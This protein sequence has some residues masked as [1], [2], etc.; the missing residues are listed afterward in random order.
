MRHLLDAEPFLLDDVAALRAEILALGPADGRRFE[1]WNLLRDSARRAPGEFGWFVPFVAV[2]TRD[3]DDIA[4][5]RAIIDAYLGKLEAQSFS[6]GLQFHFWCFAFPHAKV[7]LYF[8]WLC[9]VGAYSDEEADAIG[10]QLLEFHFVNFYYGMRDKPEPECVD[11]QALSL[12]LST[13][14]IGHLFSGGAVPSRM[15]EILRRDGLRRLP[16]M[17]SELPESGYTGEGSDYMN[18][19]VAPAIPLAVEVLERVGGERAVLEEP[20]VA[21]GARPV[22]VLRMM[23]RSFMPG[24]LLLPWDN[25]GYQFGSRSALAYGARRTG[26]DLFF[27]VLER[28]VIWTYDIGIGWAYDDLVWTLIWWPSRGPAQRDPDWREWFHPEVGAALARD[29]GDRYVVQMWDESEPVHPTRAHVNPNAVLFSG[30][31]V[32]I[33]ADGS[34]TE[35]AAH[36]FQFDDTWR[37][38]SFLAMDSTSRYNFGD[39]CA[40]AHSVIVLDDREGMRALDPGPQTAAAR[41]DAR[42]VW[43]DVTPI[44]R[45]NLPDVREVSRRTTLHPGGLVT[46]VDRVRAD[47]PHRVTSR[48]VV[49]PEATPIPGGVRVRTPE[50]VTLQIVDA[51]DASEV[52]ISR[53]EH[54]PAKP[55][56]ASVLVDFSREGRDVERVVVALIS[57][58]WETDSPLGPVAVIPD[59]GG[60]LRLADAVAELR[61]TPVRVPGHLPAYLEAELPAATRWWYRLEVEPSRAPRWLRLPVGMHDP[62]LVIDGRDVDLAP[63]RISGALIAPRVPLPVSTRGDDPVEIVLALSVPRGHYDGEGW[64][65]IGMTGGFGLGGEVEE[66]RVQSVER[67]GRRVRVVTTLGVHDLDLGVETEDGR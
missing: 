52:R 7:A 8:Q 31:R 53:A 34:P 37:E 42:G 49:R 16:G 65:T 47:D 6:T 14:L 27:Q 28:E 67:D 43:A 21:G 25:Y 66:E 15:A 63:W 29:D 22:S 24:G 2:M 11:N 23:A 18:C 35:G 45:Q 62:R 30:F 56:D 59:P 20:R 10:A 32:P 61:R 9:S 48:F 36:R 5:A 12:V 26:E 58:E 60:D 40:G 13:T 1:L 51:D 3:P 38:V 64:G 39:G 41:R 19:V 54:V 57:R 44:Y 17:L 33:S 50:G 55:D 4:R 46:L